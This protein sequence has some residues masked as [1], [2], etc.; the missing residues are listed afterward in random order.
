MLVPSR[1]VSR[2][3]TARRVHYDGNYEA[4][5]LL[6][7][8][9]TSIFRSLPHDS[10]PVRSGHA[11]PASPLQVVAESMKIDGDELLASHSAFGQF[12]YHP[13]LLDD[14]ELIAGKH[15]TRIALLT[16]SSYMVMHYYNF[17]LMKMD[18]SFVFAF[19]RHRLSIT[20]SH[21]I[22]KRN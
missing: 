6:S 1:H 11:R 9:T 16:F 10:I 3:H 14:P 13:S 12:N 20:S 5:L 4:D 19:Y 2:D 21:L 7:K 18:H 15:S 17:L 22:S 8:T